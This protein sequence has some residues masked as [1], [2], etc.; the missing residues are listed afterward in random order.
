[1]VR[2]SVRT[3]LASTTALAAVRLRLDL[4][5]PG[6]RLVLF[7][8]GGIGVTTLGLGLTWHFWGPD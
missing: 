3:A 5:R 8:L 1:V 6:V 7:L 4:E 2:G